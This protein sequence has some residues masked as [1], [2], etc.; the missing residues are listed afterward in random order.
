ME[1][2]P[3]DQIYLG[4]KALLIRTGWK[5]LAGQPPDGCD[6]LPVVEIK[7]PDRK[8][9]GSRGAYKPDLIAAKASV[10][11]LVECKPGHSDAD[12]VKLRTILRDPVRIRLLFAEIQQ[13]HLLERRGLSTNEAEFC[14]GIRG[15]LAHSGRPVPQPD[16]ATITII[17]PEGD[18]EVILP[19]FVDS[20]MQ[21]AF[22]AP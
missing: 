12:A 10:F 7:I 20:L 17:D 2:L 1:L 3:E 14:R 6:N 16:L 13:R 18:G 9:I 8:S 11:L 4:A 15:A 5:V 19:T 22:T 21:Y